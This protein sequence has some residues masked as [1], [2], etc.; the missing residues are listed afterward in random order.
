L[1]GQSGCRRI[2][3][4][5]FEKLAAQKAKLLCAL[6]QEMRS[7]V[8]FLGLSLFLRVRRLNKTLD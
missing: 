3:L 8:R 6:Q 5:Q 2:A 4:V 1:G 7:G